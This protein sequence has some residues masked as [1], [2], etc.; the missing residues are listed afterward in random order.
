MVSGCKG[1]NKS[2]KWKVKSEKLV[3]SKYIW[4]FPSGR[5]FIWGGGVGSRLMKYAPYSSIYIGL[6]A[7]KRQA[8]QKMG[9]LFVTSPQK[10]NV[11]ARFYL[12]KYKK[13]HELDILS[14]NSARSLYFFANFAIEFQ[15]YW[16]RKPQFFGTHHW[17]K[18]S[19]KRARQ[20][21]G[22][23][24]IPIE[25]WALVVFGNVTPAN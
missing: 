24:L 1:T 20:N 11:L 15:S 9:L 12:K 22:C 16:T 8:G 25:A 14:W 13:L 19:K 5:T 18:Q 10:G 7:K 23:Q 2:E 17:T 6:Y 4:A 21:E 3:V